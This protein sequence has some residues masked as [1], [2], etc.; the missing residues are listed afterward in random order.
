MSQPLAEALAEE[1]RQRRIIADELL[2]EL[3]PLVERY[4]AAIEELIEARARLEELVRERVA[5]PLEDL[6]PNV[7]AAID[8]KRTEGQ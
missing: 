3:R 8:A 7:R 6:F 1:A 2:A 5:M 4:R